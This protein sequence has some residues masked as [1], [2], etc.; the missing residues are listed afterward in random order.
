MNSPGYPRILL[1]EDDATSAAFLTAAAEALPATVE[2]AGSLAAAYVAVEGNRHDVWLFDANL[3]DG[4][5]I[6]LLDAL[7]ARGHRVPAIAHTAAHDSAARNALIEAGFDDVLVKPLAAAQLQDAIRRAL[8]S[9]VEEAVAVADAYRASPV[10][11][12]AIAAAAL[13]GSLGNVQAL[14]KLCLGELPRARDEVAAAI[15]DGD[16]DGLNRVLHKLRASCGF[17]GASRL[18]VAVRALQAAPMSDIALD[19]FNEALQDTLSSPD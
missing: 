8:G 2:V 4:S 10:W 18:D 7:R 9:R 11:D 19:S 1:V 5:G 13:K 12:D 15:R 16:F 3:P 14:R 6:E 17:V